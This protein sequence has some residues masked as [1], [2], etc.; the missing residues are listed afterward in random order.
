MIAAAVFRAVDFTVESW[1]AD[2]T[3]SQGSPLES[4]FAGIRS[5]VFRRDTY[6]RMREITAGE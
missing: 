4:D 5:P 1:A 2:G 3:G 6:N